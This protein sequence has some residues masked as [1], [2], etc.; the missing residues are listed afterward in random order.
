M[1]I[2]NVVTSV[3][4]KKVTAVTRREVTEETVKAGVIKG[5]TRKRR[6]VDAKTE[7]GTVGHIAGKR[8]RQLVKMLTEIRGEEDRSPRR[9]KGLEF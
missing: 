8:I 9:K 3:T 1:K 4:R 5:V 6:S 2:L 7:T